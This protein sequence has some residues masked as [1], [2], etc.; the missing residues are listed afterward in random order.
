MILFRNVAMRVGEEVTSHRKE[1]DQ[2]KA[3]YWYGR[4]GR[5]VYWEPLDAEWLSIVKEWL[6]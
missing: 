4:A 1:G 5:P 3:A 2:I 6:E